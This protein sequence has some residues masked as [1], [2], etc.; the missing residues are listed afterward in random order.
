A[1]GLILAGTVEKAAGEVYVLTDGVKLTWRAYF[2]RLTSALDVP[3]PRISVNP[4]LAYAAASVL[5]FVY[6]LLRISRRPPITRYLVTH[7]S[8]DFHFSIDKARRELGYEP[9]VGI[10]EAI[11]RTASWYRKIVRGECE[12][13][14]L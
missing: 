1:D 14:G 9:R 10:D 6:R 3:P 8:E 2:E 5:E 12:C 11:G 4:A 7:L 13:I